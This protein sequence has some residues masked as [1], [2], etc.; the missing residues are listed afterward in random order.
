MAALSLYSYYLPVGGFTEIAK[1]WFRRA[2]LTV[3]VVV[4]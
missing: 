2:C 1:Q 3:V 4:V